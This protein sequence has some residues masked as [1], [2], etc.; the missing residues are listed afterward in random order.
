MDSQTRP[1][2]D[3]AINDLLGEP[4]LYPGESK[5]E[6]YAF[7]D[8]VKEAA[9]P[10]D[11]V[12]DIYLWEAVEYCWEARRYR[13]LRS[14]LIATSRFNGLYRMLAN[15][16]PDN[17]ARAEL[18]WRWTAGDEAAKQ[19]VAKLLADAGMAED[20]IP[21]HTTVAMIKHVEALD[22]LALQAGKRFDTLLREIERRHESFARRLK[23]NLLDPAEVESLDATDPSDPTTYDGI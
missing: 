16:I 9:R 6:F 17:K 19:E 3:G 7:L 20:Q 4:R 8:Q 5:E 10:K 14:E 18:L 13:R 11:S 23:E 12:E 1:Q 15:V 22:R 21:A 2:R